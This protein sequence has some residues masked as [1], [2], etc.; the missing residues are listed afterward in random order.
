MKENAALITMAEVAASAMVR[1]GTPAG[2]PYVPGVGRTP[3]VLTQEQ[4]AVLRQYGV[5][6]V[7]LTYLMMPIALGVIGSEES[8]L[9]YAA[10]GGKF[11]MM[12][13]VRMGDQSI[14]G[15]MCPMVV[16]PCGRIYGL[17][18][19]EHYWR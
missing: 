10:R 6:L 19:G 2:A 18:S 9:A 7:N 17:G 1:T 16:L 14:G 8:L 11:Q 15:K 12:R 4:H 3:I 13:C 5:S